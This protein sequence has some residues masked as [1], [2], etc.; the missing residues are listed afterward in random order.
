MAAKKT[1]AAEVSTSVAEAAQKAMQALKVKKVFV[2][3][4]GYIFPQECDARAYV[5]KDG[6]YSVITDG[7]TSPLAEKIGE[8][9]DK[10][11]NEPPVDPLMDE[12]KKEE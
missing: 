7:S 5:G 11:V 9:L 12:H 8:I 10:V 4:D 2:S 1:K 6:E 3:K